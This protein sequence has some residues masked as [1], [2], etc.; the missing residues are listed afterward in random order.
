MEDLQRKIRTYETQGVQATLDM[1]R[2][3]RAVALE[4]ARLRS[5]LASKGVSGDEVEKYLASPGGGYQSRRE[6]GTERGCC[7]EKRPGGPE[8]VAR[9][10]TPSSLVS[11][12]STAADAGALMCLKRLV[13]EDGPHPFGSLETQLETS[14]NRTVSTDSRARLETPDSAASTPSS[15]QTTLPSL[16]MMSLSPHEMSCTAAAEIIAGSH[17]HGDNSM[18]RTA[19]GCTD[20][21]HCVIRNTQ[22][23]EVLQNS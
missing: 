23:L 7:H 9:D 18:A 10:T 14:E 20:V 6:E 3:A 16:R 5:L 8:V 15:V 11:S 12:S 17:G 4:N 21:S 19:L 22:V 2:A 13:N 1:Q